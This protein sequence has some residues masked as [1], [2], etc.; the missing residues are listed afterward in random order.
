M[1]DG[2]DW[3]GL[4]RQDTKGYIALGLKYIDESQWLSSVAEMVNPLYAVEIDNKYIGAL[5]KDSCASLKLCGFQGLAFDR[6]YS[7]KH[8]LVF[9]IS[10]L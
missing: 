9:V 8:E 3:N 10:L 1:P 5:A 2:V 7:S 4:N 6:C